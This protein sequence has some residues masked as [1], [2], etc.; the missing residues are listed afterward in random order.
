MAC[1]VFACIPLFWYSMFRLC[2]C[3]FWWHSG[4]VHYV[5][6]EKRWDLSDTLR[7]NERGR[8]QNQMFAPVNYCV[9]CKRDKI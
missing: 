7:K 4:L 6:G 1:V 3:G 8:M 2:V 5:V 9:L